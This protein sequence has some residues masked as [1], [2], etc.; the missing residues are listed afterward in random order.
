MHKLMGTVEEL[1]LLAEVVEAGGFS[2]ASVR[3][4]IPKSRLSRR[5]AKLEERLGVGLIRRDSRHFEVTDV[6]RRLYEQACS[7]RESA[8]SAVGLASDSLGEPNGLLRVGC[9]VALATAIV[10]EVATTFVQHHPRVQLALT[11]T[12]GSADSLAERF[13]VI[14]HPSAGN[15]PDSEMVARR[16][17]EA[18]YVL[19]ATPA[20]LAAAGELTEPQ[21]LAETETI[22]WDFIGQRGRWHLRG[23]EGRSADVQIKERFYSDNLLVVREAALRG[24]GIAPIS[25]LL[26][27]AD[28]AAGRLAIALPGW[29]PP[30]LTLYAVY[31][32]RR[33]LSTAGQHFIEALVAHL[34]RTG[35]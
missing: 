10:T 20:F 18:A 1:I 12:L 34:D 4:G 27:S 29:G 25:R 33:T 31:A 9:P 2:A 5:I 8:L 13:D 26:A 17:G 15:L 14:I 21:Q 16:L 30:P 32:S 22:G 24:T 3:S 7:I 28:I 6:G 23:P 19:V 11:T 35:L